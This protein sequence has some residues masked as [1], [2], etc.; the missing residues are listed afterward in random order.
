MAKVELLAPAGDVESFNSA[1]ASG[2]DAIYLGL[3]DFNARKKAQNFSRDNI[4]EVIQKAH[5][6]DVKVYLTLNTIVSDEEV[7]KIKE[8]IDVAILA[9]IDAFLV[10]DFGVL[11]ILTHE[12]DLGKI[13]IH[14]STQ[15]GIHNLEGAQIAKQLGISRVVLSRETTKKDIIEISKNVDIDLEFFVQGALCVGFSGN[16]YMSYCDNGKS[17]NRGECR[18]LCRYRYYDPNENKT[19]YFLSTKDICLANSLKE[20]TDIGIKSFKIEGR[21]RRQEYVQEAVSIYRRLIDDINKGK[22]CKLTEDEERRLKIAYNR[23]NY[24][25]RLYLDNPNANT[26]YAE[27]N[28]H[29]GLRIGKVIGVSNRINVYKIQIQSKEKIQ[30]G[31]GLKFFDGTSEVAS[32]GV[33]NIE[34]NGNIYTIYSKTKVKVGNDVNLISRKLNKVTLGKQKISYFVKMD[35][36]F[37]L[38]IKNNNH[39]VGTRVKSKA[40]TTVEDRYIKNALY[41]IYDTEFT[42]EDIK[43]QHISETKISLEEINALRTSLLE[44]LRNEKVKAYKKQLVKKENNEKIEIKEA[45]VINYTEDLN[46]PTLNA[47]T[48]IKLNSYNIKNIQKLKELNQSNHVIIQLPTIATNEDMI[49]IRKTMKDA[50]INKVLI[51]NIYGFAIQAK[52]KHVDYHL[53]IANKYATYLLDDLHVDAVERSVEFPIEHSAV[54]KLNIKREKALMTIRS[55]L[56]ATG[57][58][59]AKRKYKIVPIQVKNKYFEVYASK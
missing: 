43:I 55:E 17:G 14:A 57:L 59:T 56:K 36:D 12:Y 58:E 41:N 30:T 39:M 28:N 13:E 50:S 32:L 52:E 37:E 19:A 8:I 38:H 18:Q 31:D 21:L 23:G 46:I 1:L 26:I 20:L 29:E 45:A 47:D 15:M 48:V 22:E 51:T 54:K 35:G 10:Q 33:G 11:Y 27:N 25:K 49:L 53:N 5:Q 42:V 40:D 44:D 4:K 3:D 2:A 34:Q 16:C 6:R 9:D 24:T 7:S